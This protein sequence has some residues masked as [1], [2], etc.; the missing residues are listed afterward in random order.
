[1]ETSLFG[2]CLAIKIA[3]TAQLF[4]QRSYGNQSKVSTHAPYTIIKRKKIKVAW[5]SSSSQR[6]LSSQMIKS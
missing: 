3:T 5:T 6:I 1:M 2:N 4:W